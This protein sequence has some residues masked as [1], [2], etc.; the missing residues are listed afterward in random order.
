MLVPYTKTWLSISGQ[1][2]KLKDYGLII[3]DD[4]AAGLFL[5][6]INY[7]R[8][9]GYALAFETSRHVLVPGTTFE[10]IRHAYEFDRAL[11]DLVSESLE[12]IELD[13]RTAVAHTFAQTHGPFGHTLDTNFMPVFD[14]PKREYTHAQWLEKLRD[15]VRRTRNLFVD[16]YK[17][18]YE[19]Y[20]DLP[21][22]ESTEIMSFGAL[23]RMYRGM[24]KSDQKRVS[25]RYGLQPGIL[26]SWMLHLVYFRNICAHHAR[27]WDGLWS[28]KPELPEGT[29]WLPPLV[30]GNGRL[31][32]SLLVQSVLLRGCVAEKHFAKG[33]RLR[34][35]R[36][37][38]DLMPAA[39]DALLKMGLAA[40]WR[41]HPAWTA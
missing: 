4:T 9:S 11:R 26:A 7:F 20:P 31:F 10:Q 14:H 34:V 32:A 35:E 28:I 1:V 16:H 21:I 2:Q 25:A 40:D 18:H 6:H 23:A 8:F 22:W 3:R 39:P 24:N 37:I 38:S 29:I 17:A 5:Q 30:P 27:L 33:W 36:L 13:L 15:E 41:A 19:E 12:V